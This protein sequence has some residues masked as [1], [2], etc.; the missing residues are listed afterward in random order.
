MEVMGEWGSH[1]D[2]AVFLDTGLPGGAP[3][4][5]LA[6]ARSALRA[7]LAALRGGL[8]DDEAA[9]VGEELGSWAEPLRL[10][11][12]QGELVPEEFY[13]LVAW[14]EGRRPA[15]S[16][17]HAQVAC[18]VLAGALSEVTL[19]RLSRQ[20]PWLATLF[21]RPDARAVPRGTHSLQAALAPEHTLAAGRPGSSQPLSEARP[22]SQR[23]LSEAKPESA[24]AQSVARSDDPH[25][26]TKLSS[27][28]GLT[29]ERE[30]ESLARSRKNVP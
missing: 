7:A 17:E 9:A 4:E 23:P 2:R 25:A 30:Q 1:Y 11:S 12:Y 19:Q 6:E 21:A 3:F 24:H 18:A 5:A 20:L 13:R 14:H 8:T 29:Q 15:I 22:T 28:S 27:A 26:G 16:T 10:G